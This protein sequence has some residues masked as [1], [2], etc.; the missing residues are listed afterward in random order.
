MHYLKCLL[1]DWQGFAVACGRTFTVPD[2]KAP[3]SATCKGAI[4]PREMATCVP[5]HP[6]GVFPPLDT[7][8]STR[9]LHLVDYSS[10]DESEHEN[11]GP[12]DEELTSGITA[13][14]MTEDHP[15]LQVPLT[16]T[17]SAGLPNQITDLKEGPDKTSDVACEIS[18]RVLGCL[19]ELRGVVRRLHVKNL[20]PYNP[21]PLLKL[22]GQVEDCSLQAP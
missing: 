17:H 6:P 11:V 9:G 18:A 14:D 15:G 4:Q 10:S 20:F 7:N 5:A 1:A 16:H 2:S 21:A 8:S 12:Q 22:L 3:P 13:L 19:S